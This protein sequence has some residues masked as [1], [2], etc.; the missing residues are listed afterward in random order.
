MDLFGLK[1]FSDYLCNL[2]EPDSSNKKESETVKDDEFDIDEGFSELD[3]SKRSTNNEEYYN[4]QNRIYQP[5]KNGAS[6]TKTPLGAN[7]CFFMVRMRMMYEGDISIYI[8]KNCM[9][10]MIM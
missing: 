4:E 3:R 1:G 2:F 9:K 10:H 6:V 7:N 8:R 5:D